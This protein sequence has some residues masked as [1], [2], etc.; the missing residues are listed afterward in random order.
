MGGELQP[1]RGGRA[2]KIIGIDLGGP[3]AELVEGLADLAGE[4]RAHRFLQLGILL[5]QDLVHHRRF[6][7]GGLAL[8]K[9]LAGVDRIELLPVVHQYHGEMRIATTIRIRSC[10]WT[11]EASEPS[12][13][14]IGSDDAED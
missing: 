14:T 8:G 2:G 9:R 5:V 13:T 3:V 10:A 4:A 6:H 7:A 11:V 12:S 1:A